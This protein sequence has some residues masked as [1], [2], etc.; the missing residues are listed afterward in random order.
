MPRTT[1]STCVELQPRSAKICLTRLA[2][3]AA[4]RFASA[5][6]VSCASVAACT[7]AAAALDAATPALTAEL[8]KRIKQI[9][10]DRGWSSTRVE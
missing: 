9:F 10:A 3:S 4:V 8:V 7:P 5:C 2:S 6:A 1:H